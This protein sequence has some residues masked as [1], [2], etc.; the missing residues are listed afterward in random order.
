MSKPILQLA[1]VGIVG[2]AL[3]KLASLFFLP[4]LFLAL[5]IALIVGIAVV[6]W[7]FLHKRNESPPDTTP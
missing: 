1:A 3:W 5:K 2:V 7:W 6:A 4:V